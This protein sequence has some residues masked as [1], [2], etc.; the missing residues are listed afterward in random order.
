[1]KLSYEQT[2]TSTELAQLV[3][4]ARDAEFSRDLEG[5][6]TLL[7][8]V[9]EN[10][11]VDPVF[12]HVELEIRAGLYRA[13]GYFIGIYGQSQNIKTY[14]K[15]GEDLIKKSIELFSRAELPD[16]IGRAKALLGGIYHQQGKLDQAELVLDEASRCYEHDRLHPVSLLVSVTKLATLIWRN[17]YQGAIEILDDVQIP[18]ELCDDSFLLFRYHNNAG[19]VRSRIGQFDRAK[20]HFEKAI[21]HGTNLNNPRYLGSAY[22]SFSLAYLRGNEPEKAWEKVNKSIQLF[23]DAN[24][25]GWLAN[26]LDTE[27][28]IHF[29]ADNFEKALVSIDESIKLFRQGDYYSG[30]T[31]SMW[32]KIHI[33]LRLDRKEEAIILFSELAD[34]ASNKIGEYA[35]KKYADKFAKIIHVKRG[36]DFFGEIRAFKRDLLMESLVEANAD[37]DKSAESLKTNRRE[38]IHVL[39]KEF[40]D[41]YLELGMSP[42]VMSTANN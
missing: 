13:C 29:A 26:A 10:F 5:L 40:P 33:L 22:N 25:K 9:W 36:T 20:L 42:H 24:E 34:I 8:P 31:D 6:K 4:K 35:V 19:M 27:A 3:A 7:E 17:D 41:I 32:V 39:N 1:M 23:N 15:R 12:D 16:E 21:F 2:G 38:I 14:L 28:Q 18:M 37:I 30:L 11:D